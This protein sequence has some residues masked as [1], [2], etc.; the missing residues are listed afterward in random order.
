MKIKLLTIGLSL[1]LF[2]VTVNA[3]HGHGAH[4]DKG[5]KENVEAHKVDSKFKDQL[6]DVY[7]SQLDLKDAFVATD[8]KK[9]KEAVKPIK[10]ALNKVDMKLVKDKAHTDWMNY[11][12]EMKSN[13]EKIEESNNIEDQRKYFSGFNDGLYKSL[14]AF[15]T[16]GEPAYYQYCPMALG[17]KGGSWLSDSKE[18]R[19]PYFGDKML[20]C[21]SVKETIQ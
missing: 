8:S 14:K 13:L 10:E 9:V 5:K 1:S 15:G 12:N 21:G 6:G 2:A 7:S 20:K 17:N 4:S 11:S 16:S 18:I 3:Q 19:N